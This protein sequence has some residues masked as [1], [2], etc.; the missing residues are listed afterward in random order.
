M[1]LMIKPIPN[2]RWQHLLTGISMFLFLGLPASPLPAGPEPSTPEKGLLLKFNLQKKDVLIVEKYQDIR[3][4]E[5]LRKISREEKNRIVLKVIGREKNGAVLEGTFIT[6]SRSPRKV[7]EYRLDRS[8]FSRFKIFDNG[9]YEVPDTYI[10]PNLRDLPSFPDHP[11]Q[12]GARWKATAVETVPSGKIRLKLRT[13]VD[14]LYTGIRPLIPEA[15]AMIKEGREHPRIEYNYILN[16][17]IRRPDS[18]IRYIRGFSADELWFDPG[19]GV[20]VFDSNRLVYSFTLAGGERVNYSFKILTWY[21]KIRT[22]E[23]HEKENIE[24]NARRD[25]GPD[26]NITVKKKKEGVVLTMNNI[27]FAF[28]SDRLTP[29][30]AENLKKIATLLGKYPDREIRISGHTD[31]VGP[32]PYNQKLSEARART[33]LKRLKELG[34]PDHRLS[35]RGYGPDRPMAP[36]RTTEGRAQNRR[37]E[38]LIVTE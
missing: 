37:V 3:I 14:Y 6:Y 19:A 29:E 1:G 16:H 21:R 23:A 30:A 11:V 36:N 5:G 2:R 32:R 24:Q 10:M 28:D 12:T 20:P 7:G 8:Y 34:I 18:L 25:L 35:Y 27:L 26:K 9:H 31:T 17:R 33:V 38:I 15:L 13:G 22:I 4:E